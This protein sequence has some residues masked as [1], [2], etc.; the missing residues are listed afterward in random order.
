MLVFGFYHSMETIKD[1]LLSIVKFDYKNPILGVM[2][3]IICFLLLLSFFEFDDPITLFKKLNPA[4]F[5][6]SLIGSILR[7]MFVLL[8]GVIIAAALCLVYVLIYSFFGIIILTGFDIGNLFRYIKR[9]DKYCRE[10]KPTIRKETAC[11]PYTFLEKIL[12]TLNIW[13]DIIYENLFSASFAYMLTICIIEYLPMKRLRS[14]TLTM[15]LVALNASIIFS[16]IMKMASYKVTYKKE[17]TTASADAVSGTDAVS[18]AAAG[19]GADT[20]PIVQPPNPI[21]PVEETPKP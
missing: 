13:S 20:N 21:V 19:T 15:V 12:N 8:F 1:L 2:Y 17:E 11:E 14:P 16:I 9:I 4:V 18:G 7:Y 3:G 6:L 5:T 10:T